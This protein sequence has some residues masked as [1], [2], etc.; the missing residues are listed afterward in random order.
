VDGFQEPLDFQV[1]Q[2]LPDRFF[3]AERGGKI[4]AVSGRVKESFPFLD[5]SS[6]V[7]TEEQGQGLLG[8]AFHPHFD[9]NGYLFVG[10]TDLNGNTAIAR[11]TSAPDRNRAMEDSGKIILTVS[12]P[13][14]RHNSGQLAFG[15][16][17][18]LYISVGDGGSEGD[19]LG[20]GQNRQILLGKILRIDVDEG[21]PYSIPPTNPF[22]SDMGVRDEIWMYG[23]RNP[24]RF[25]FDPLTGDFYIPD[26]GQNEW[27]EINIVPATL[28][29]GQN[30]G[31]N[32]MEGSTCFNPTEDCDTTGLTLPSHEYP[33][34]D[35]FCSVI[36]GFVY[37]GS[38]IPDL[39]GRY[40]F[41]DFCKGAVLS[42][43][44]SDGVVTDLA[45][46]TEKL[47]A[48]LSFMTSFG[49]DHEGE[50]YVVLQSGGIFKLVPDS[51]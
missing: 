43:H 6:L 30:F 28:A 36:G 14:G 1:A 12:Q 38:S 39:Q 47:K 24:W 26:V 9:T 13:T 8:F 50:V 15:P 41:G 46:W 7:T 48:D 29:G 25:S 42:L 49:R 32:V 18:Y 2:G 19:S 11:Y 16:D 3:V 45:D 23:L 31:W 37:R 34:G 33:H 35:G 5:I 44:Y 10:Y 21:D 17:G 22:V 51:K 40:L 4:F 20:N 27:E